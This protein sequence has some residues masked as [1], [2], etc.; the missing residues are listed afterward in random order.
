MCVQIS[1]QQI[2]LPLLIRPAVAADLPPGHG[3]GRPSRRQ[4][5]G[6]AGLGLAGGALLPTTAAAVPIAGAARPPYGAEHFNTTPLRFA[7][8]TDTHADVVLPDRSK[9]LHRMLTVA[10]G[11]QPRLRPAPR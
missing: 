2:L 4:V 1:V 10:Q 6:L 8:I 9:D 3:G 7:V 5:L 11:L